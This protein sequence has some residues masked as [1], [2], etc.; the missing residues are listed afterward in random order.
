MHHFTVCFFPKHLVSLQKFR[1]VL[2]ASC[3]GKFP[4]VYTCLHLI[5]ILFLKLQIRSDRRMDLR[6]IRIFLPY[7]IIFFHFD[8]LDSI[9]C[10]NVK[11]THRLIIFRRISCSYNDPSFRN[12]LVSERLTLKKLQHGRSQSLRHAVDLINKENA[13]FYTGFLYLLVDRSNDLTHGVF[14]HRIFSA[15]IAFLLNKRKPHRTLPRVMRD[16]ICHQRNLTLSGN[17]FHDLCL[18][19]SRRT[20]Q[21]NRPLPDCRNRI[22]SKIVLL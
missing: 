18:S 8:L 16:R 17:L 2:P 19:D 1:Q 22:F 10:H 12:L 5:E 7:I 6:T 4:S 20:H 14:R 3:C 9:Q 13:F 21:K 15:S 11:I